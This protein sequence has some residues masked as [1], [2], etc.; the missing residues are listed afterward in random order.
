MSMLESRIGIE[1]SFAYTSNIAQGLA[2]LPSWVRRPRRVALWVA[3]KQQ[4][5]MASRLVKKRV[6]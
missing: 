2:G 5:A 3:M 6:A 1:Q 4:I